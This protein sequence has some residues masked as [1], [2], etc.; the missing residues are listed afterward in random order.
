MHT[1]KHAV[2]GNQYVKNLFPSKNVNTIN[3]KVDILGHK[4]V[5]FGLT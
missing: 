4:Y 3:N 5:S 2:L 1:F